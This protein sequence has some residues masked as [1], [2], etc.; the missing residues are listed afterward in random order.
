VPPQDVPRIL[1]G[2]KQL[3]KRPNPGMATPFFPNI[4]N[5]PLDE[6]AVRQA[7]NLALD[8]EQLVRTTLSPV[9][10]AAT[11][12][13]SPTTPGYAPQP[14]YV[15]HDLDEAKRLLDEAGWVPGDDGIR[16]KDG[17][18]LSVRIM[19]FTP[20]QTPYLP[21]LQ[22]AQQ[23]LKEAGIGT[24]LQPVTITQ[25]VAN[26]RSGNYDLEYLGLTRGDPDVLNSK[27]AGYDARMDE[28]L[29]ALAAEADPAK[30]D[31]IAQQ[32]QDYA[33]QNA[34]TAPLHNFVY[35]TG[36]SEALHGLVFDDSNTP[37]LSEA[38]LD[39]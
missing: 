15:R 2:G 25:L 22:L 18:P 19:Y 29:A 34:W 5:A 12:I 3:T 7:I 11:A 13:L 1:D 39:N 27:F 14:E 33:M 26:E 38:W 8:R 6:L 10:S 31:A 21:F 37:S 9:E 28:L 36:H 20:A 23:Q 24:K 16:Q 30:R 32:A 17:K 35:P 4:E